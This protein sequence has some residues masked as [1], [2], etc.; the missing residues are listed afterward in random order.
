MKR[1]LSL[2]KYGMF[3]ALFALAAATFTLLVL[4]FVKCNEP[5]VKIVIGF[6]VEGSTPAVDYTNSE[7]ISDKQT[8][9][10]ILFAML[11]GKSLA[12][13]AAPNTPPDAVMMIEPKKENLA[14]IFSVWVDQNSVIY[15]METGDEATEYRVINNLSDEECR[16]FAGIK[17]AKD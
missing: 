16:I 5:D 9:N 2:K 12:G 13:S 6:P 3:L 10:R 7:P 11:S 15:A 4:L 14:Y 1:F 17:T 8:V